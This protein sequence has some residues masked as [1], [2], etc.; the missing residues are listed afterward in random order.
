VPVGALD[1]TTAALDAPLGDA[2]TRAPFARVGWVAL[3]ALAP[4]TLV[5][6]SFNAGGYFPSATGFA[7]LALAGALVLRTTLADR[8]FEGLDRSLAIPLAGLALY[9]AFTLASASWSQATAHAL[10]SYSRALLYALAFLLFGSVRYTRARAA[11]LVR[12]VAAGLAFVCLAGLISRVL[13]HTSPTTSGFYANQ[14]NYPKATGPHRALLRGVTRG[15]LV[16]NVV[17]L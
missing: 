14:L 4:A 5:Y 7:A 3:I 11:W 15:T 16:E 8:P 2:L 6:L 13:P 9:A 17:R 10:D 1:S 12:A